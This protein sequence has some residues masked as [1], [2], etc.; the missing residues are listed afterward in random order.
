[1]VYAKHINGLHN[2]LNKQMNNA[3][4]LYV[5]TPI[6]DENDRGRCGVSLTG[7][8]LA[9]ILDKHPLYKIKTIYTDSIDNCSKKILDYK[10]DL[11][12][13]N[14]HKGVNPWIETMNLRELYAD[15]KCIC[16]VY[17]QAKQIAEQWNPYTHPVWQYMMTYDESVPQNEGVFVVNHLPAKAP[18]V[19]YVEHGIPIIGWQGFPAP[20]KGVHRIAAQ[21]QN[22]FDEAI[23]RL[24]MPDGFFTQPK[25]VYGPQILAQVK[26]I[27]TKPGIKVEVSNNWLNEQGIVNWLAQNTINC[28][29]YDYLDGAGMS[30]SIDYA[31]AARRPIAITKSHQFKSYWSLEPTIIIESSS[32][33]QIIANG[34]KPWEPVYKRFTPE[35]IHKDF[36]NIFKRIGL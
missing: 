24:H 32:L 25:N 33:K 20:W 1:M 10:P 14:F 5:T 8:L 28:Y 18:T 30:G 35:Q 3:K 6:T 23:I 29:F 31:I 21:V 19:K 34:T 27:I 7:S 36:T 26:S 4:I 12:I 9:N 16:I 13:F 11:V 17:D 22:E 15:I 2:R